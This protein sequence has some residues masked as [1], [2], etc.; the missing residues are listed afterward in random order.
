[1]SEDT[2]TE[3]VEQEADIEE[4]NDWVEFTA[5]LDGYTDMAVFMSFPIGDN[6][7]NGSVLMSEVHNFDPSWKT[8]ESHMFLIGNQAVT[9]MQMATNAWQEQHAAALENRVDQGG[10]E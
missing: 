6:I 8:G 7:A 1:M 5:R 9:A 4:A 2:Q 3:V 10:E